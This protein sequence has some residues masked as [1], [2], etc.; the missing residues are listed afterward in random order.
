MQEKNVAVQIEIPGELNTRLVRVTEELNLTK[1]ALVRF[2]VEYGIN[3]KVYHNVMKVPE[4]PEMAS[5]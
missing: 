4:R 1:A 5:D 2:F 3:Y